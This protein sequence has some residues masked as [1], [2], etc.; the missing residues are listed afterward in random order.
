MDAQVLLSGEECARGMEQRLNYAAV[1]D[2]K[3]NPNEEEYAGDMVHTAT[4][5]KNLPLL[6]RVMDQ[7]LI[8]LR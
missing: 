1:K 8:R 6:H 5:T 2:A 7:N 4:T 3:I